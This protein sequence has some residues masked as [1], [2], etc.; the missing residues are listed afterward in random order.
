V[1]EKPMPTS[2]PPN[3]GFSPRAGVC[4]WFRI[5]PFQRPFSEV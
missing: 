1:P 5:C 3:T 2:W 4:S